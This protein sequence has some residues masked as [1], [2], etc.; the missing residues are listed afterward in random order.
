[1]IFE[2]GPWRMDIS[3][4]IGGSVRSLSWNAMP[5]LASDDTA[6]H[7]VLRAGCFAMVPFANRIRDGV[8]RLPGG[9]HRT[10][11]AGGVADRVHPLHG[12]GWLRPWQVAS[13]HP[14]SASLTL[15][16]DGDA[17]WPWPFEASLLFGIREE[18]F[19]ATL[20]LGNPGPEAMPASVGLHPWFPATAARFSARAGQLWRP[21]MAGVCTQSEPCTAI[22][23]MAPSDQPLDACLTGWDGEA[24]IELHGHRF[25]LIA[26]TPSGP[27]VPGVPDAL[28]VYTPAGGTRFCLEPQ[29]ARSGAFETEIGQPGGPP[30]LE[31]GQELVMSVVIVALDSP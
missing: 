2:T 16:H 21:D 18:A 13:A 12:I 15:I 5:V 22:E 24:E 14:T 11:A 7:P 1:M 17:A 3:P 4:E 9:V 10:V 29:T 8:V 28:H 20:M 23:D 25:L 19:S 31:P 30:M 27:P 26:R 6:D